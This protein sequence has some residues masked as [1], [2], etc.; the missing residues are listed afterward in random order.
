[1]GDF[2]TFQPALYTVIRYG[3]CA[4]RSTQ[5]A[6]SSLKHESRMISSAVTQRIWAKCQAF[7]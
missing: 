2:N 1:M 7:D 4:M 3:H 5:S 6:S